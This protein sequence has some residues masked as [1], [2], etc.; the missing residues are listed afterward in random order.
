[1]KETGEGGAVRSVIFD[2]KSWAAAQALRRKGYSINAVVRR[3]VVDFAV[4]EGVVKA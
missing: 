2:K 3:L 1:M 4:S